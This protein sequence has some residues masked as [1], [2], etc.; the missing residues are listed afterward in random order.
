MEWEGKWRCAWLW[1]A[2]GVE[3]ERQGG[4]EGKRIGLA[5]QQ[6]HLHGQALAQYGACGAQG[7]LASSAP[8][9]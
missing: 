2:Q 9:R 4:V 7:G 1:L 8:D 5:A 6:A 3:G